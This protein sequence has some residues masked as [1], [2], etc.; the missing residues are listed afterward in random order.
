MLSNKIETLYTYTKQIIFLNEKT[1]NVF[2][3]KW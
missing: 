1:E 3:I 2:C